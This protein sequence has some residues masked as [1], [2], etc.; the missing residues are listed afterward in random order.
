MAFK[1]CIC[2][3]AEPGITISLETTVFD[4]S[5]FP[6]WFPGRLAQGEEQHE[7]AIH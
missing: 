4:P 6:G 7:K 1:F 5:L 2:F 3:G